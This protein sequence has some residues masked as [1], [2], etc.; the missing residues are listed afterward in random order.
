M[1]VLCLLALRGIAYDAD[2]QRNF[3]TEAG[4][5]LKRFETTFRLPSQS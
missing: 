1:P 2:A 5:A 4:R 3:H